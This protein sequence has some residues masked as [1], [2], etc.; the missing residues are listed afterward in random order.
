MVK[1]RIIIAQFESGFLL[2]EILFLRK[3]TVISFLL[4]SQYEGYVK[5]SI[6]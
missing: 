5:D 3:L 1:L 4:L 2:E 6:F